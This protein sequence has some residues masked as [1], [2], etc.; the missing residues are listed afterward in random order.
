M[1]KHN[2]QFN[3]KMTV[4]VNLQ[5]MKFIIKIHSYCAQY[6]NYIASIFDFNFKTYIKKRAQI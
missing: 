5:V 4:N 3:V 6:S 2:M 1:V